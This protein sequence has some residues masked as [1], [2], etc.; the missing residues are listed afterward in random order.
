[1]EDNSHLNGRDG[2]GYQPKP[3]PPRLYN[4]FGVRLDRNRTT[5]HR[6]TEHGQDGMGPISVYAFGVF[7]CCALCIGIVIGS[8]L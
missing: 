4:S 3:P 2:W 1:M 5:A 8:L 6:V 7:M